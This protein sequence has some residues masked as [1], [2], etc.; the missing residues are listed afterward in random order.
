MI[1]KNFK[2]NLG[3]NL[4]GEQNLTWLEKITCT[5]ES[6]AIFLSLG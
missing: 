2:E 3:E 6:A 5:A 4:K 1:K